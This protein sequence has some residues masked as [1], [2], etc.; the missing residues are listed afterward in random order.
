MSHCRKDFPPYSTAP[1]ILRVAQ[2]RSVDRLENHKRSDMAKGFEVL[3]RRWTVERTFAWL[4]RYRRLA[5]DL[6]QSHRFPRSMDQ[7]EASTKLS[8]APAK[9]EYAYC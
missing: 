4:G 3:P 6:G 5:K 9:G 7:T 8:E 2:Y 1:G